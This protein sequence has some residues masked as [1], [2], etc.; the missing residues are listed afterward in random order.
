M[1]KTVLLFAVA[2]VLVGC[3][4]V[5]PVKGFTSNKGT[6]SG[7]WIAHKS[8]EMTDGKVVCAGKPKNKWSNFTI[9]IPFTCDDG[10]SGQLT[11]TEAVTGRA[12]AEFSDGTVGEFYW[13]TALS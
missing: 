12:T 11:E 7:N 1:K 9:V 10:R 4:T 8:F 5:V 3:S 6:W 13:G 2:A